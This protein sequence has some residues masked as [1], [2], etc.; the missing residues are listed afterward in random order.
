MILVCEPVCH[1]FEHSSFNAAMLLVISHACPEEEIVFLAE[2]DHLG[3]VGAETLVSSRKAIQFEPIDIPKR[4]SIK[5]ERFELE[6]RLV[7]MLFERAERSGASRVVFTCISNE[8]LRAVKLQFPAFP[9]VKCLMVM[10]SILSSVAERP[11]LLPWKNRDTFRNWL[12]R[13][14]CDR[15]TYIVLGDSIKRELLDRV[16]SL[17]PYVTSIDHPYHFEPAVKYSPFAGNSITFGALGVLRK[18]KGSHEFLRLAHEIQKTRT[19]FCSR[20]V[21]IGP[22]IDRKLRGLLSDDVELPSPDAPLSPQ[23][24]ALHVRSIDYA[25]FFHKPETYTLTASGVLF[26]AFSYLKPVIALRNPFFESYFERMGNIGYLCDNY[27]E[28]KRTVLSLLDSPPYEEYESQR[29]NILKGRADMEIPA[30]A[31]RL[32]SIL[33]PSRCE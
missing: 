26:D 14:N 23:D 8:T 4:K 15:L 33:S 27:G 20:F 6:H 11:S 25:I 30:L 19:S 2:R 3:F 7:R 29:Q 32:R 31:Q 12:L 18:V 28:L 5:A 24:Y 17:A 1:G 21:C 9:G 13:G 10:H 22:I 16:P